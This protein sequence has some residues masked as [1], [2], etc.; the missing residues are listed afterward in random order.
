MEENPG[1]VLRNGNNG[2]QTPSTSSKQQ[3]LPAAVKAISNVR[4]ALQR[5]CSMKNTVQLTPHA[6]ET[7]CAVLGL[8]DTTIVNEAVVRI[9]LS[10]DPFPDLGKLV[11]R[12]EAIRR[13]RAGTVAQSDRPQLGSA[14]VARAARALG[15]EVGR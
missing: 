3:L 2:T 13:E 11:T 4:P 1:T 14:A 6:V 12:C 5:L 15:L 9:G 8:Y 10:E 7:W